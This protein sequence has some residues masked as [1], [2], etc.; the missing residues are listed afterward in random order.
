MVGY[1]FNNEPL[2][3]R[4]ISATIIVLLGVML[5]AEPSFIFGSSLTD[6]T[7]QPIFGYVVALMGAVLMACKMVAVRKLHHEKEV[8][9]IC[10]YSQAIIGTL[11]HGF[12]FS[13]IIYQNFFQNLSSRVS[14]EHRQLAWVILWTVGLLTIWVNFGINFALRRIVAGEAALIGST[15]VGYAYLLQ[16]IILEQ[17]NSPLESSGVAM[18]MI[19]LVALACYNIYLQRVKKIECDSH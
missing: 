19:S 17:S 2:Y 9:L 7:E 3:P 1:L 10:L 5:V 12:V 18:M 6:K 4:H 16:F 11:L 8:L 13:Y 15:E 14:A